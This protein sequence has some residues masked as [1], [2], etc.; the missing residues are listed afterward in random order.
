MQMYL[1][2]YTISSRTS[3]S[4]TINYGGVSTSGI[5]SSSSVNI[6][7]TATTVFSI[8]PTSDF[9]G[10][11]SISI[12]QTSSATNQ[13]KLPLPNIETYNIS[14]DWGDGTSDNITNYNSVNTLHTYPSLGTYTVRISG[15]VFNFQFGA[16][17]T[18]DRGKIK[19]I[20]TWGGL[21]LS[22]N[23]FYNCVN[24][25]MSGIT[26]IPNLS[27]VT[28]LAGTFA[29]CSNI[30]TIGRIDEWDMTSITSTN[31]MFSFSTGFTQSLS[32]WERVG[33]TLANVT[34]MQS[35]FEQ[36]TSFNG[37]LS[38]WNVSGVTSFY[39]MFRQARAF[40]NG[41]AAGV[42]GGT[43]TW[44]INTTS[45]VT[46]YGMFYN[47]YSF[48]QNIGSWNVSKVTD[49]TSM[50]YVESA[51]NTITSFNNG[52]SDSIKNWNVGNVTSMSAMFLRTRFNNGFASGVSVSNQLPWNTSGCTNMFGMFY[53]DAAFNSNLGS[54]STPW[55]VSKVTNMSSMFQQATNFNNGDNTAPI[56][57]WNVSGVTNMYSMFYQASTFNQPIGSWNVSQVTTMQQMFSLALAFNQDIGNWNVSNVI[58]M[59]QMFCATL[60]GTANFNQNIGAWNVSKVTNFTQMF[61][62]LSSSI[63]PF[64]NGGSP[65]INNWQINTAN[66]VNMTGMFTKSVF[67][68]PLSGWNTSNVTNMSSMF[69]NTTAFNQN[70]GSWNVSG[71]TNMSNMFNN[72]IVFN[73]PI[74][75]WNVSGVTNMSGMFNSASAFNQP[76]SGWNTSNVTTM[77]TMFSNATLFNQP[78]GSWNVSGVTDMYQ[79]FNSATA[80]NQDIGSWNVSGVTDFTGFMSN[81]SFSNFSAT[82]LDS[83]YNGW[84]SLPSVKPSISIN[85][86]TIKYTSAGVAGKAILTGSPYNWVIVDG[87]I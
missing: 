28:S 80:F 3:G 7:A 70:I 52:G 42:S 64:N 57:N 81:K 1:I 10:V 68:Q 17:G 30:T 24:V 27:T 87:G 13:I 73:Q 39:T 55:D 38:G 5:I 14:V 60:P 56:N 26:D 71:V 31:N 79:M 46:M 25:T 6:L 12:K 65:D 44:T 4:V 23:S 66:T 21:K 37:D 32:G 22:S 51:A 50:F 11:V 45:N 41:L 82:N 62:N 20:S 75:S 69:L 67:N 43:M 74:G 33:S 49:M 78:I 76:L 83:I 59:N 86:G 54:G 77:R 47:A 84:S 53:G 29:G 36:A 85:F 8:T 19:T 18:N 15:F 2:T 48:N 72:D 35:M 61:A 16:S 34:N 40:N 58:N 9:D 63:N